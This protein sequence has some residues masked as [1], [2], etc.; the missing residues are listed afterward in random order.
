MQPLQTTGTGILFL[1]QLLRDGKIYGIPLKGRTV[2]CID[3]ATG[4]VRSVK[5]R[6]L[7]E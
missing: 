2:L 5:P 1:T 4:D 3:P 7:R 6:A